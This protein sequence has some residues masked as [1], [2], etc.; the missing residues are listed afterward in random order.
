MCWESFC[1]N[2]TG[3][4]VL[5]PNGVID[6]SCLNDCHDCENAYINF[7]G[8]VDCYWCNGVQVKHSSVWKNRGCFDKSNVPSNANSR[9]NLY[10][11]C[12]DWKH[13]VCAH[14]GGLSGGD[15]AAIVLSGAGAAAIAASALG[16]AIL[17]AWF[18]KRKRSHGEDAV[19]QHCSWDHNVHD[20]PYFVAQGNFTSN[21]LFDGGGVPSPDFI[22]P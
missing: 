5:I 15:I 19:L 18:L 16:A 21:Q 20:N 22:T 9:S 10:G 2:T 7:Q 3:N 4:C 8:V 14:G 12:G 6:C 13:N 17:L 1:L 11:E